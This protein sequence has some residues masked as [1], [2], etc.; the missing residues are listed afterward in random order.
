MG[1]LNS[2]SS[3]SR[4]GS[5]SDERIIALVEELGEESTAL[6]AATELGEVAKETNLPPST[7]SALIA[8]VGRNNEIGLAAEEALLSVA[9]KQNLTVAELEIL[10]ETSRISR[11]D[12]KVGSSMAMEIINKNPAVA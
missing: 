11:L 12:C 4:Q 9:K 3:P 7:V 1:E 5:E 8:T 10:F 6:R 2:G